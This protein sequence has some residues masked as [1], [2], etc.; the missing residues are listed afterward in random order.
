MIRRPPRSTLFPYTTLFREQSAHFPACDAIDWRLAR[1]ILPFAP[2]LA[3][4]P[5][6]VIDRDVHRDSARPGAEAA[7][8]IEP[9]A[10]PVDAPERFDREILGRTAITHEPDD[11]AI[12]F[13][14][15]LPK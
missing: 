10:A 2:P 1:L 8:R 4:D 5:L 9:R 14:L 7:R 6:E 13:T 12:D 3:A 11:P 15:I